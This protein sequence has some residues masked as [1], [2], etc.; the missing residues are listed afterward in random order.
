MK[1]LK[2]FLSLTQPSLKSI[3]KFA[4]KHGACSAQLDKFK[5]FIE[6]GDELS[7]WQTVQGNIYWLK[8][9][10][11]RIS[12]EFV[13]EKS[14]GIG[15]AWYSNGQLR[16]QCTYNLK[17]KRE[18]LYQEWFLNGQLYEK[19]TYNSEGKIEGLYQEWYENGQLETQFTIN[20]EGKEEGLYQE[21]YDDG[22]LREERNYSN[23]SLVNSK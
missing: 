19:F 15:K 5:E 9:H 17:G 11:L 16:Q 1:I 4:I 10:K 20:S 22:K 18:G 8:S 12:N 23:G 13:H 3:L 2:W 21:W 14:G 7:A 6:S